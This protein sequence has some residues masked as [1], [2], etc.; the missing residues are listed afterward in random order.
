M[1]LHMFLCHSA[2]TMPILIMHNARLLAGCWGQ[3]LLLSGLILVSAT[4]ESVMLVGK[5][6]CE[7]SIAEVLASSVQPP[8]P[9]HMGV[10]ANQKDKKHKDRA[11]LR[12]EW[13]HE[14][15]STLNISYVSL[16]TN[17]DIFFALFHNICIFDGLLN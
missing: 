11:I 16:S 6:Q 7:D 4:T 13:S 5:R 15:S 1:R 14:R 10:L 2:I 12:G 8:E 9:D 17:V 3:G